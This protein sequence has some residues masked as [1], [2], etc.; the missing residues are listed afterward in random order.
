MVYIY[1]KDA[2]NFTRKCEL[3]FRLNNKKL[4]MEKSI[5]GSKYFFS[6]LIYNY[7]QII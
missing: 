5:L 7:K 6:F 3:N 2:H 1:Q 4:H